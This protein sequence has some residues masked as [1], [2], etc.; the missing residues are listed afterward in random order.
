MGAQRTGGGGVQHAATVTG[1]CGLRLPNGGAR[2]E[3]PPHTPPLP[4]PVPSRRLPRGV[5]LNTYVTAPRTAAA[6]VGP[7][8]SD[9]HSAARI[10]STSGCGRSAQLCATW[11]GLEPPPAAALGWARAPPSAV[12][13]GGALS[14][15]ICGRGVHGMVCRRM[16]GCGGGPPP[17]QASDTRAGR[18]R[19]CVSCV[20]AHAKTAISGYRSKKRNETFRKM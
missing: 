1:A 5:C 13:G 3:A 7:P 2:F 20:V 10:A 12:P 14:G 17:P 16:G 19:G 8:A 18:A 9:F 6:A 15:T 11:S 4:P